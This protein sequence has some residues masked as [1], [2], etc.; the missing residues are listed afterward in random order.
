MLIYL[1][2]ELQKKLVPLFH[3]A[4]RPGGFLLLGPSESLG[5]HPELFTT[6]DK[7][8]RLLRR[9]G[10]A[11]RPPLEFPLAGH[12]LSKRQP[13]RVDLEGEPITPQVFSQ[14]FERMIL[15]EYAPPSAVTNEQGDILYLAGRAGRYLQVAAGAPTNNIFDSRA[16]GSPD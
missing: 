11:V 12:T 3:Y 6:V 1:G 15:E 8:N 2:A 4:L 13:S 10:A 5:A 7:K 9:N 16:R 14:A